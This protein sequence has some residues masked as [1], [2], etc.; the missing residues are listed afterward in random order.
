M[1]MQTIR[2]FFPKDAQSIENLVQLFNTFSL[3]SEPKPNLTK[4]KIVGI[5]ALKGVQVAFGG[6][7]SINLCDEAI[8]ILG[9]FL[10]Q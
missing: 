6:M 1:H 4:C 2:R 5:E 7:K 8:K 3:F 10:L 9:T